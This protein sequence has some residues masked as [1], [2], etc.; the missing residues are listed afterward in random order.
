M[1]ATD[2]LQSAFTGTLDSLGAET[3]TINGT[4]TK[5]VLDQVMQQEDLDLGGTGDRRMLTLLYPTDAIATVPTKSQ[6][7]T[8]RGQSWKIL[9][10]DSHPDT[11]T[12]LVLVSPDRRA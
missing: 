3:V 12:R 1:S 10:V 6:N 9:S 8:A 11:T 2:F 4:T 7:V 5:A